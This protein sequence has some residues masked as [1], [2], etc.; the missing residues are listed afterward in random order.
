M[1]LTGG[2]VDVG[3]LSDCLVGIHKGLADETILDR[4]SEVRRQKYKDV[5]NPTSSANMRLLWQD[6]ETAEQDEFFRLLTKARNDPAITQ[7]M[8]TVS[9]PGLHNLRLITT[10][11]EYT[12]DHA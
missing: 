6:G 8:A 10:C 9:P 3:N 4:Y 12:Q 1:G 2:L 5:V 7:E 11:A